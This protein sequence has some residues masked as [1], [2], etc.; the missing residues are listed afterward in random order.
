MG[1]HVG[2]LA[3]ELRLDGGDLLLMGRPLVTHRL[4]LGFLILNLLDDLRLLSLL[5]LEVRFHCL[6]G[7]PFLLERG[8]LAAIFTND[9]IEEE[10][11]VHQVG[12][13][14]GG[15]NQLQPADLTALVHDAHPLAEIGDV[16]GQLRLLERQLHLRLVDLLTDDDQLY[17]LL[18]NLG[19]HRPQL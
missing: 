8:D 13:V 10:D 14:G 17:R 11:P 7:G 1:L 3:L 15:E 2:Q 9:V 12:E 19:L 16:L 5:A 18:V 4:Q 6:H